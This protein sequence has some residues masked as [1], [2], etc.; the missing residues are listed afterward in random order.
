MTS[1][2]KSCRTQ[3]LA[4][5][6]SK[7]ANTA[8]GTPFRYLHEGRIFTVRATPPDHHAG[9]VVERYWL[10]NACAGSMTLVMQNGKVALRP[11]PAVADERMRPGRAMARASRNVA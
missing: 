6:V 10:C 1:S 5:M 11:Q 3:G 4:S 2:G 8:C 7:C 9:A